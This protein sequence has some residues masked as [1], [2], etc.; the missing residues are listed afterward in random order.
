MGLTNGKV[1]SDATH[2]NP[3]WKNNLESFWDSDWF[4]THQS[5]NFFWD[6]RLKSFE[7]IG[8]L[9]NLGTLK[10]SKWWNS[11]LTQ[12]QNRWN[13]TFPFIKKNTPPPGF[14]FKDIFIITH[15]TWL[16]CLSL[17]KIPTENHHPRWGLCNGTKL[18]LHPVVVAS[19]NAW[20][21][22]VT[23]GSPQSQSPGCWMVKIRV[24]KHQYANGWLKCFSQF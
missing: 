9:F 4:G 7:N 8:K 14:C 20:S 13:L 2:C 12:N 21:N 18:Q 16:F 5:S 3:W 1:N 6:S 22:R 19:C 24:G 10:L 17:A 23:Q 11:S 15:N